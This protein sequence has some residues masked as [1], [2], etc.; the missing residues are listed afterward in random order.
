MKKNHCCDERQLYFSQVSLFK[1]SYLLIFLFVI[2]SSA[3]AQSKSV[4]GKVTDV[5]SNPLEGVSVTR[6]GS[7]QGTVSGSDGSFTIAVTGINDVLVFSFVGYEEVEVEIGS[8]TVLNVILKKDMVGIGEVVV[9]AYGT[10]KRVN[11]T[12]AVSSISAKDVAMRPI[13][14]ATA[15]LQGLAPGV[16]ITQ[17]SGRPGADGGIIRVRGIGTL[18]DA[19]PL[20]IIDGIE[21]DLNSLDV[22]LIESISVL[23][24]AASSAIYG[25]RA[26]NGVILVTTRRGQG[27]SI[28]LSLNSYVG[29]QTP[30]DMPDMVNAIDHMEMMNLAHENEGL[31]L[32]F[33]QDLI[34]K[35]KSEGHNNRD[36]YPDTDWAEAVLKNSARIQSHFLSV[37]GGGAKVKFMSSL[38]YFDQDGLYETSSYKR[39]VFR[40]NL[41]FRLSEK[42]N[43]K[44]DLSGTLSTTTDAGVGATAIFY[45]IR[46]TPANQSS[47][48]S[49]GT[50]G[51]GWNGNNPIPRSK[52]EGGVRETKRPSAIANISLSYKPVKWMTAEFNAAPRYEAAI[53]DQFARSIT[54]YK[55]DGSVAF[56]VPQRSTLLRTNSQ[57]FMN[58]FR[59]TLRTQHAIKSHSIELLAG[60]S[61]ED[62]HND[63]F[64]ASREE[65]LLPNYPVLDAGSQN[66]MEN[67]GSA[68][69]WA[70]QSLFS[71][72]NY[73][74]KQKYLLELNGRYDGSSR[75]ARGY[76]YGFFPSVSAGWRIME[77]EF[78]SSLRSTINE[79]KLRVS[80]GQLGNQNIGNYPFTTSISLD[81]LGM[82]GQIVNSAVLTTMANSSISWESST[83]TNIGLDLVIL[84]DLTLSADVYSKRTSGILYDLDIPLTIGLGKPYQNAGVV[85]NKGWEL[86]I[87]YRKKIDDFQFRVNANISD[88][89]N[90]VVDLKGVNRTGLTVSRE[91][92]SIN[93]IYGYEAQGF[94]QSDAEVAQHA[95]QVGVVK[96][97]DIKYK[98]QNK[99]GVIN[100]K[101]FVIIGSTVPR[102]TYSANINV[103]YKGFDLGLFFQGVG[104]ADGY[105][106]Q[107]G[108]MPFYLG[109]TV[110]EIHK[111]YW[112]PN[113]PNSTFPRLAFNASN[114]I[115]NSSFWMKN[116]A[117][118]RLKNAQI[119]YNVPQS[120]TKKYGISSMRVFANAQN[121]FT[122]DRFWKGYDVETPV[123]RGDAYPQLKVYNF[124]INV[125]F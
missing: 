20:V 87:G 14:Q 24:D 35:Y 89:T 26:A 98:D 102:Y 94:F 47:I 17:N 119:G 6:K 122:L 125:T 109:G 38:S 84:K 5:E 55:A 68:T 71:R 121:L 95:T 74:Y 49:D 33:T 115:Q 70:L 110:Q 112:T 42:I 118:L 18:N 83:M 46:R 66:F 116:A 11:L 3:A 32:P 22:N 44:I 45:A 67:T 88:V 40:N 69:E 120:L 99:D 106:Y 104:K 51:E 57:T 124:G 97:G 23:K 75:F 1:F 105:I 81:A 52:K 53:G 29:F 43:M 28:K 86:G 48:F 60:A 90:K 27:E 13:G 117:Y 36:L 25:S 41:D 59:F 2:S 111:D 7:E 114:N 91:G 80:W 113:S 78:M 10:Q 100:D 103:S 93:S 92:T 65:F 58:N 107:E 63:Q 16:T 123:G 30:T 61:R 82:G 34:N 73:V 31:A 9:V 96:A 72:I 15:A 101:D 8:Q 21:G 56:V 76:K 108:I 64:T 4:I 37:S 50:W 19:N 77:E 12:G 39:Y 79:A 62:A 54:T 85:D